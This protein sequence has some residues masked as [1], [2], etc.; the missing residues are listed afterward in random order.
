MPILV[1]N[2]LRAMAAS[3]FGT[4]S[5]FSSFISGTIKQ[6]TEMNLRVATSVNELDIIWKYRETCIFVKP[7]CTTLMSS[8]PF[9]HF[10]PLVISPLLPFFPFRP[11]V[12][13][14]WKTD[15]RAKKTR[16]QRTHLDNRIEMTRGQED[17]NTLKYI[18]KKWVTNPKS[19]P[20]FSSSI[21][22]AH[23]NLRS[24]VVYLGVQ[25]AKWQQVHT[26][27]G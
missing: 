1:I 6:V 13:L 10:Y 24:F 22:I 8:F 14:S 16:G 3:I 12:C 19:A 9:F 4:Q 11:L 21:Q 5:C 25:G 18:N 20:Y 17:R 27:P 26:G 23:E 15:K 2:S 7:Y